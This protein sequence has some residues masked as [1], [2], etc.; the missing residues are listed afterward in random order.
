MKE[1]AI[2]LQH[3]I[4]DN[5][6]LQN[7]RQQKKNFIDNLLISRKRPT[8]G[9]VHEL[10]VAVKRIRSY[11]RL[12]EKIAGGDWKEL[13]LTIVVLF[14]SFGKLSD[15]EMSITLTR[16]YQRKELLS[17]DSFR[18]YL[19][20]NR[21][22]TRQLVR[23]DAIK[24]NIQELDTL[25]QQFNL[26]MTDK[27]ICE[28]ILDCSLVKIKKVKILS[29]HFQKNA[30]KIRKQLKDVYSWLKICPKDFT[31]NFIRMRALDQMLK[32]L[33]NWQDHYVLRKKITQYT[34]DLA[35]NEEKEILKILDTKLAG[36]QDDL[37]K[38]AK[39]KWKAV[40][41]QKAYKKAAI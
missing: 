14:K 39:A 3:M 9:S 40:I 15:F 6:I 4:E 29:K 33:G 16:Q 24:F 34:K 5:L 28:K 13:F 37:L 19:N 1:L 30:H 17:F 32:S 41:V 10:R 18:K 8:K 11:L 22:L 20:V 26:D 12:K 31:E 27:E 25:N 7:W 38:K 23:Q 21:T 35:N 2:S 36:A